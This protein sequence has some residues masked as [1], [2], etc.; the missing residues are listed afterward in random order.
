[1]N[2]NTSLNGGSHGLGRSAEVLVL[3]LSEVG[4]LEL[5][6]SYRVAAP[7]AAL[8]VDQSQQLW[9]LLPAESGWCT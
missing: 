1:M 9:L 3:G 8:L 6:H 7:P 4:Q 2:I 5:L